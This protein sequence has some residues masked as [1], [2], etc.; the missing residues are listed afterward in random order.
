MDEHPVPDCRE[1]LD[2]SHVLGFA[3]MARDAVAA[4][5]DMDVVR[6]RVDD[7]LILE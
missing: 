7:A 2:L 6:E 1:D 4:G 3:A 5:C